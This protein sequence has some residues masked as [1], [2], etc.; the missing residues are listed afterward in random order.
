MVKC[1][2]CHLPGHNRRSCE[3]IYALREADNSVISTHT[4][5][6]FPDFFS[7]DPDFVPE[8]ADSSSSPETANISD[9]AEDRQDTKTTAPSDNPRNVHADSTRRSPSPILTHSLD[10]LAD[11]HG[12]F[13]DSLGSIS[14]FDTPTPGVASVPRSISSRPNPQYRLRP[15]AGFSARPLPDYS[16]LPYVPPQF[17]P[18]GA[19]S[20]RTLY[21]PL[22]LQP[23]PFSGA[24]PRPISSHQILQQ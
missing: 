15:P 2:F 20:A 3:K 6:D 10:Q 14:P 8:R 18:R 22:Q 4:I 23:T 16:N 9:F 11:D 17:R 1:G 7:N 19:V 12:L 24:A 21:P 5:E 13:D